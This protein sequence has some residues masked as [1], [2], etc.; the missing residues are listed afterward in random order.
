[1]IHR[2]L[3]VILLPVQ[4]LFAQESPNQ[5]IPTL[6]T[7]SDYFLGHWKSDPSACIGIGKATRIYQWVLD[8]NYLF[9]KTEA[10]FETDNPSTDRH[11]DW[12]ISSYDKVNNRL[13]IREFHSEGYVIEYYNDSISADKKT[14][15]YISNALENTPKG[16]SARLIIKII[17]ENTFDEYFDLAK[18]DEP[19]KTYV[20]GRWVRL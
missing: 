18:P 14:M 4:I 3:I 10:L 17:N 12:S 20:K 13:K 8:S 7:L 16:W 6:K 11:M 19:F 2:F 5:E 9:S 1:M 15:T